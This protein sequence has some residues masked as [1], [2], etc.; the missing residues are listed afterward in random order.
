MQKIN[1]TIWHHPCVSHQNTLNR[2]FDT[3]PSTIRKIIDVLWPRLTRIIIAVEIVTINKS[4]EVPLIISCT[5]SKNNPNKNRNIAL[6]SFTG[7]TCTTTFNASIFSSLTKS[8]IVSVW[9]AFAFRS[10]TSLSLE[11]D[12][13]IIDF[14]AWTDRQSRIH[15]INGS[16][17]N[18]RLCIVH[19]VYMPRMV[20]NLINICKR[21]IKTTNRSL[22][23]VS[24]R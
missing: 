6:Q 8:I 1:L 10:I 24:N 2:Y 14:E 9:R 19:T 18:V 13:T 12:M 4:I 11:Y 15:G 21:L 22:S 3:P 20:P 23:F 5:H 7:S 17:S 16:Q